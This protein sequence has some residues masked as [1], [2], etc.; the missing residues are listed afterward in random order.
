MA[1]WLK[2]NPSVYNKRLEDYRK[3]D[4]KQRLWE[5]A[6]AEFP[7]VDVAY[8]LG[9]YKSIRTCFGKLSKIPS[10][11]GAQELTDRDASILTKFA[12]LKSHITRQRGTQLEGVSIKNQLDL[13]NLFIFHI[14]MYYCITFILCNPCFVLLHLQLAAKL[15]TAAGPRASSGEESDDGTADV[16]DVLASTSTMSCSTPRP[17]AVLLMCPYL[18]LLLLLLCRRRSPPLSLLLLVS[19]REMTILGSCRRE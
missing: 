17:T 6:A 18:L 14:H 19:E 13:N 1:K 7:N 8:L 9:L 3:T 5:G 16:V 4:M 11:S 12:F 2:S 15:A 10:G